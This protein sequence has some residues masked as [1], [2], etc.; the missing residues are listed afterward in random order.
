MN[1]LRMS[2]FVLVPVVLV[3]V[4]GSPH[5]AS[6]A[7]SPPTVNRVTIV[8]DAAGGLMQATGTGFRPGVAVDVTFVG[9]DGPAELATA[10]PDASGTVSLPAGTYSPATATPSRW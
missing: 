9:A 3:A 1:T 5:P 8:G 10:T 7:A 2:T 4:V 6:A